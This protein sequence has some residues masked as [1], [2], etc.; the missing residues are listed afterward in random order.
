MDASIVAACSRPRPV[1]TRTGLKVDAAGHVYVSSAAGVLVLSSLGA[2]LGDIVLP[3]A[4]NFTFG[5]P[6]R[7]V[8]F[9]TADTAIWAVELTATSPQPSITTG[10][11]P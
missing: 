4:V 1:T 10:I 7:N 9:V 11:T 5:E 2:R 8:L 6:D 3:G